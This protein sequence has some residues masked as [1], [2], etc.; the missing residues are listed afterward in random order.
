MYLLWSCR[1][2]WMYRRSRQLWHECSLQ[3]LCGQLHLWLCWW[4]HWQWHY[5]CRY[6]VTISLYY[7]IITITN[8]MLCLTYEVTLQELIVLILH[9]PHVQLMSPLH[10]HCTHCGFSTWSTY[11]TLIK[12]LAHPP[13]STLLTIVNA[14]I[15]NYVCN[16]VKQSTYYMDSTLRVNDNFCL[17][18]QFLDGQ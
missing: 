15:C 4:L 2:Q 6:T 12:L 18:A 8:K 3:W 14:M 11:S 1:H 17:E 7:C 5:M 10:T 13:S 9:S 16:A